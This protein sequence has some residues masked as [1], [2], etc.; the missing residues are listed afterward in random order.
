MC[1][2]AGIINRS[3]PIASVETL[4]KGMCSI[5]K[6][7]GPDDEGIYCDPDKN[8]VLGHR[9]LSILDLT[10]AGHQPMPYADQRYWIS[11]NG[12]LYNFPELRDELEKAGCR[13]TTSCD[14][15][16][17]LA[18]FATWGTESFKRFEG[19][20][21]FA[22]WDAS[23]ANLYLVRD[24]SGI[25]PLYYAITKEGLAFASEVRALAGIP[26]LQT[27]NQQWPVYL[28]AYGHLP[29][30]FT[31]LQDVR[32][33]EKGTWLKYQVNSG[34]LIGE[35][36]NRFSYLEKISSRA[37]A[38]ELIKDC[39]RKAVRRHLLSDAPIGVFLSGGLD[40][41][42]VALL[43]N[44]QKV[45]LNTISLYFEEGSFSEKKYQDLLKDKLSCNHFQH[46]LKEAEFHT[47]FPAILDAMD[48][49]SCDGV[50][51]WFISKYARESGLKSVLSGV[52]ADELYGGYP[53][54]NRI[55]AALVLSQL[56]NAVLRA[57][58]FGGSKQ[59]KRLAYLSIDG[60]VGK[61]LFL[62][63]QFTPSEIAA[64]LGA[65]EK[66]IWDILSSQPN[67]PDISY[68]A[69]EN[70]ASWM[71]SNMYMQNQ[72]LRDSD[73]M[74]MAHGLEIRVPFLDAD[75]IRL[76]LQISS[77]VKYRGE[78]KKQLLIDAFRDILPEPIWNR[79]KMGFAF[80]F[81]DWL[82]RD[83]YARDLME[84]NANGN[85]KKFKSGEMH[86]SHYLASLIVTKHQHA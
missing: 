12:E 10:S 50:N 85:H 81:K 2:I 26:W 72:L 80:P 18:A 3:L 4:V 49:P 77:A 15:E 66:E 8:L 55:K 1:R 54:F 76:T 67:L 84:S 7:G 24:A 9:R 32:P 22:L 31:T 86:W 82:S 45:Q 23:T 58:R 28:M 44:E 16:V 13:F 73:V 79:P 74:S 59:L 48:L 51:T 57:G 5:L 41:S 14:T 46:L 42:L 33:L 6:A 64:N 20:F 62:R 60:P 38:I 75:F 34:E 17:I 29:E 61:Y 39:L 19:M 53:S 30:P 25:K 78:L 63:G 35:A 37:E 11:Y 70:Q 56:P 43:A 36:F 71:E 47:Y 21:A 83:E 65:E 68:L 40:S 69:P 52:G 27:K